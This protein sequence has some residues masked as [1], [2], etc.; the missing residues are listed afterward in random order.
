MAASQPGWF[1]FFALTN[2]SDLADGYRLYTYS[3]GTTTHKIAYTDQAG[4]ISHTYTS[5]GSG[6]LYIALDARGE[7][8]APLFLAT[9]GYDLALKT[10]A[11]ATV[12]TRRAY[13][14]NDQ[15]IA[16]DT[17]MRADLASKASASV[18][19]GMVGFD[20]TLN[21]AA[22]TLGRS[23]ADREWDPRDY[24]W[25][26]KF[27]GTTDDTSALL[28]CITAIYNAGGGT[29]R[30]P[31][32]VARVTSVVFN[33]ASARS[34]NII[35]AGQ[36]ATYL[37]K[38]GASTTPVLDLS[39]DIGVLDVYSTFADFTIVGASKANHGLRATR[40]AN[41]TTRNLGINACDT[42]FEGVGCL[43]ALH[44]RPEW[45]SNNIG[46]R[47]RKN[48][49]GGT[50]YCNQVAFKH[51]SMRAN[52]TFGVDIGDAANVS[53][54]TVKFDTNGTAANTATGGVMIRDT[55]D[56]ETGFA[57]M[58]F[59]NCYLESNVGRTF[60]TENATNL[61]LTL[62]DVLLQSPESNRSANIGAIHTVRLINVHANGPGNE[63]VIGACAGS[64]IEGGVINT[65][66]DSSTQQARINVGVSAGLTAATLK[67][68][69]VG[70]GGLKVDPATNIT[71]N[72]S[73]FTQGNPLVTFRDGAAAGNTIALFMTNGVGGNAAGCQIRTGT[74]GVTGRSVNAGGTFN[75]S[76]ADY[77]E[78]HQK[79]TDCGPIP[80][81]AIVGFDACG[82]LTDQWEFAVSFGVKSTDPSYV[83]GDAWGRD[84][85]G[86][87]LE[88][89]R[90]RVDRIAYAGIAPV[91]VVG[92]SVGDY[93]VPLRSVDGGI[94]GGAL[95]APDAAQ[96]MLAIGRVRR[97]M[98]D[99]RAEIAVKV[100]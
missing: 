77:A 41:I 12:W 57:Q 59:N 16:L 70:S 36:N 24:P 27:D 35:G 69:T 76:G 56:D 45:S 61:D 91:N 63:V 88:A 72:G 85:E 68:L 7:I 22:N 67:T 31:R 93:I 81:G 15:A 47:S 43:V 42:A 80:K 32:G 75:A 39:A 10:A 100:I 71:D 84:L 46:F 73:S 25:L 89:A 87:A 28:A 5:D 30:M 2:L 8:P 3:A 97:V 38:I 78:Y 51:G 64:Y 6:G 86:E 74:H 94:S 49:S 66:T 98:P 34:V 52:T 58:Q 60:Q 17:A 1:N 92:A 19:A 29:M 23:I 40:L 9:G 14:Q 82:L 79:R 13:G 37:Q 55:V 18:G 83:G 4:T 26:A 99:G 65:I 90:Q 33:W 96:Y 62:I 21:Y 20:P 95:L 11:G 53:F 54:D 44:E 50:I 48:T